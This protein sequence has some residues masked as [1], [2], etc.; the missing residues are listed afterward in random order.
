MIDADRYWPRFCEAI[1]RPELEHDERFADGFARSANAR[2]LVAEL[3]RVFGERTLEQWRERLDAAGL[4]WSPVHTLDEAIHDPQAR[5]LGYFRELEHPEAG[6][7]DTVAP[8]MRIEGVPLGAERPA[9]GL[10]ADAAEVLRE[11]G[12]SDAEIE[13]LV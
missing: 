12:L 4:I 3:E 9:S 11:A 5:T 6:R 13:K 2:E 10:H 7:F 8:P 1:G